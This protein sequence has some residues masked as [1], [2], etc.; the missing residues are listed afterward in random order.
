M[1][2]STATLDGHPLGAVAHAVLEAVLGAIEPAAAVQRHVQALPGATI[3][4]GEVLVSIPDERQVRVAGAG[5]AAESMVLGLAHALGPER[6]QGFVITKGPPQ[7]QAIGGV[8]L[9]PGDHPLPGEH[10]VASTRTLLD[11]VR[12]SEAED[13]VLCPISGGA[14]SLLCAPRVP[15]SDLRRVVEGCLRSGVPIAA[16]NEVR[17]ALDS[18]K[19]GGLRHAAGPAADRVAALVLSDVAGDRIEV[20]GSGPTARAAIDPMKAREI[21]EASGL[22]ADAPASVRT[23]LEAPAPSVEPSRARPFDVIVASNATARRAA[24]E[25]AAGHGLHAAIDGG[26]LSGE[27]SSVGPAIARRLLAGDPMLPPGGC[28]VFGGETTVTHDG[29]RIGGRNLELALSMIEPLASAADD[30]L[31]IC[32]ATDGEDGSSDAAGA[33]VSRRSLARALSRGLDPQTALANHDADALFS[34]LG[35]RIVTGPT[36][37][38]VADLVI[39]FR[40]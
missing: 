29:S 20:V 15:L 36:G 8:R 21:L 1:I 40:P 35:D 12:Q 17:A 9:L 5:K 38:N 34:A 30:L 10:S 16:L 26:Q 37:T 22:W 11:W 6:L 13:L 7:R 31:V 2:E 28:L 19:R 4:V 39:V 23:V 32:F 27:A 14:S 3:R 25:T 18:V 33:S 24:A